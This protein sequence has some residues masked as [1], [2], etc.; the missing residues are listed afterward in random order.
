MSIHLLAKDLYRLIRE[1][2]ALT[3]RL[4]ESPAEQQA[5]IEKTLRAKKA[6]RDQLR[7]AL[8][9]QKG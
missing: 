5:D 9:G 3:Q 2:D 6:E 8:E 1:V 7:R 4:A